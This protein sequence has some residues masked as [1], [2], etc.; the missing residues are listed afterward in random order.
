MPVS[1]GP[2]LELSSLPKFTFIASRGP[3]RELELGDCSDAIGAIANV[4]GERFKPGARVGLLYPSEPTLVLG[5]LA[6]LA[7]GLEPLILQYPNPKQNL[8]A[9]RR[10]I[11]VAIE[12][13]GLSGLIC[14]PDLEHCAF[15]GCPT[16]FLQRDGFQAGVAGSPRSV[17]MDACVVQMSSGTTGQRKPIR[18]SLAQIA[19][20]VALY[21]TV[22]GFGPGDRIVS[23]LPLY[24]DMG[25]VACFL[26]PMMLGIPVVM[27]DPMIWVRDPKRLAQAIT[28]HETTTC[29]MPNF[30]FEVMAR[31]A[32]GQSFPSMRR[33]ISCSEPVYPETMERF[34]AATRTDPE[35]LSACYA[36]A[37]NIFAVSHRD[38]FVTREYEGRQLTSCGEAIPGTE[39]KLVDGEIWVRSA[40]SLS[41]YMNGEP[42]TDA[43][44]FYATGDLGAIVHNELVVV[45]RKHDVLNV[46]GKKFFLNDLDQAI[47][48]L[49][50]NVDGRAAA[51]AHRNVELGTDIPLF[52]V[53]DRDFYL[54]SDL[55]QL[56]ARLSTEVDIE[57]MAIEFVPPG[58]LSKT[59]S[60]KISRTATA[61]NYGLVRRWRRERE[62]GSV[63]RR[64]LEMDMDR[65]FGGLPRDKPIDTLLDSLG[66]VSLSLLLEDAGLTLAKDKTLAE[67]FAALEAQLSATQTETRTAEEQHVAIVSLADSRTIDKVTNAHVQMLSEAA[68]LPV[69]LEHVC[70]PPTPIVLSD[71]VFADYFLPRDPGDEYQPALMELAKLRDASL[72]LVDDVSELLFGRFAY[73]VL[74]HRFERSASADLLAWRWQK[75]THRHHELPISVV[76]LR[77]TY[78]LRN[79]FIDRLSKYLSV[80]VFRIA[81]LKSFP[82][83]TARWD[84]VDRTNAD[85]TMKLQVDT[86]AMISALAAFLKSRRGMMA[87]RSGKARGEASIMDAQHFCSIY[88]DREKLDEVLEAF[89]RFCIIGP[90]SSLPY[91]GKSLRQV[92]KTH[93]RAHNL[94]LP[95]LGLSDADFD[96]VLQTGSWGR[97]ETQK[98]VF[99][100]F[101]AGWDANDKP[102]TVNAHTIN[103][104]QW[105]HA[106]QASAPNE[107]ATSKGVLWLL[108]ASAP[109]SAKTWSAPTST[110]SKQVRSS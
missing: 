89:D 106:D 84:F 49:V 69:T 41:S 21:N 95:G 87:R 94:N 19:A 17:P 50:P 60:G 59:S 23:W 91:V 31:H 74:D 56:R 53:E 103:N 72:L 11:D 83:I 70:L 77:Q 35:C 39:I 48:A 27:T 7:A 24:H 109:A 73:P 5:W 80:P 45:G 97:P 65:L 79:G 76:N 34:A 29:F 85:W 78:T 100:I 86:D 1:Q 33:W 12:S 28:A 63:A 54:R 22:L 8:V 96:C 58:F 62:R 57:S 61:A 98:P 32:A 25:F 16:F 37:E 101:D 38:G 18:F 82:D 99:Q 42:V 68:G 13:A 36:M 30:G 108:A 105:F 10:S 40:Y 75:Y 9:W 93:F 71:L 46:A 90:E 6:V 43:E 81:T 14:A 88:V 104:A 66:F 52:L 51:I 92:G 64:S 26:M 15:G 20:H 44:G 4:I 55:P 47:G 107:S 2:N 102:V 67:H 110:P 3:D